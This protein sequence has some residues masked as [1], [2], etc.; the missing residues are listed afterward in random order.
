MIINI[1]KAV[2]LNKDILYIDIVKSNKFSIDFTQNKEFTFFIHAKEVTAY[3]Q[4]TEY[5]KNHI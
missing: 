2:S 4:Q 1:K 5:M 3:I